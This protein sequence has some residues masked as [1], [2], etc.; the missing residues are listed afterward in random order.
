MYKIYGIP[1]CNTIKKTLDWM[2]RHRIEYEF[3]DYKKLGMTASRL[4]NWSKQVGWENFLN[5]K[6]ATWR[7][8][9]KEI[10]QAITTEKKAVE[11]MLANNS[12]IKRPVIERD[13]LIV[14]IGFEESKYTE[15]FT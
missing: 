10:Q 5:K 8:L 2:D 9:S 15:F 13:N 1:N 12:I 7:G 11:L 4:K 6:S 3:Y 14:V